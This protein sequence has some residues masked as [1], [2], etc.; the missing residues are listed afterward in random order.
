MN[1]FRRFLGWFVRNL[2][3]PRFGPSGPGQSWLGSFI[4]LLILGMIVTPVVI[5]LDFLFVPPAGDELTYTGQ[6]SQATTTNEHMT[7]KAS[8]A[9]CPLGSGYMPCIQDDGK[10]MDVVKDDRVVTRIKAADVAPFFQ[11]ANNRRQDEF[12]G[13]TA[14]PVLYVSESSYSVEPLAYDASRKLLFFFAVDMA[15][16]GV[17]NG[18][19]GLF[20]YDITSGKIALIQLVFGNG[21][22]NVYLSEDNR[23]VA[24]S[25]KGHASA[26]DSIGSIEVYD[27]DAKKVVGDTPHAHESGY[28]TDWFDAWISPTS[29]RY[30]KYISSGNNDCIGTSTEETFT[31]P[32][33]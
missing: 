4:A 6:S 18:N 12:Q 32:H 21:L 19:Q 5:Y 1:G 10:W 30:L 29:F 3:R 2:N 25:K 24:Y 8:V 13:V 20:T 9:N 22:D 27:I 26:C 31:I 15:T 7:A 11:V 23:Y 14:D 28:Q 17:T 33:E 16:G